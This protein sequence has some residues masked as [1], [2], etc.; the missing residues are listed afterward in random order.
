[1]GA[2]WAMTLPGLVVLLV[3]LASAETLWNRLTGGRMLPWTRRRGGRTVAATGFEEVA[4]VFQGAK[5][6]EFEQRQTTLMHRD[7]AGDAQRRVDVDITANRVTL[8]G[9]STDDSPGRLSE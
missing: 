1:M 2:L 4:A 8:R 3:V 5:H 7:E 6:H 9:P